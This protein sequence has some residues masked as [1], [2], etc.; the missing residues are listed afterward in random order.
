MR[1]TF[2]ANVASQMFLRVTASVFL[3]NTAAEY[4]GAINMAYTYA[5]ITQSLFEHVSQ[6]QSWPRIS[7]G[8]TLPFVAGVL[9]EHG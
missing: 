6:H 1:F 9:A 8:L 4:G 2:V 5:T 3:F 7:F